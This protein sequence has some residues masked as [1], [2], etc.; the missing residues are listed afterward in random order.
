MV[1]HC[2][3]KRAISPGLIMENNKIWQTIKS[4][5]FFLSC[6]IRHMLE[7]SIYHDDSE[8]ITVF[9]TFIF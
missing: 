6:D 8:F 5:M 3:I 7:L 1:C 2:F 9:L 4:Q